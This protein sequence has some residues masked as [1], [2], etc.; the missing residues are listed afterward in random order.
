R[1]H[2]VF[3][4]SLIDDRADWAH[5]PALE[6]HCAELACFALHPR[7]Q[8]L[9]ALLKV[10]PGRPLTLDYFHSPG[11][12]RWVKET[13]AREAIDRIF[14]S[15]SAMAPYAMELRAGRLILDFMD[16]DS[17]KW[18]EY[19]KASRG[20]TRLI[21]ARE[22]RTLH[23]FERRAA[24]RFDHALFVSEQ[25]WRHFRALAPESAERTSFISNGVDF[26]YFSPSHGFENPFPSN[27]PVIVFTGAMDYRPNIQAVE[28]FTHEVLPL[29]RR[30]GHANAAFWIVG[31]N[32]AQDVR[33]LAAQPDV[34]VTGR[35]SDTRPYLAHAHVAV[36]PLR[37]ARGIQNK[38]L[39]AM[40]MGRPVVATPQAFEGLRVV[41][42][43]DLLIAEEASATAR[44]VAE[45]LDGLHCTLGSQARQ[46][47]EQQ[48]DWSTM[49]AALDMLWDQE[50]PRSGSGMEQTSKAE[51]CS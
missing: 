35:V 47:I 40:A 6:A 17:A 26:A 3:V 12:A 29:V 15:C 37:I 32:P 27:A 43:R 25:E 38:V 4:G 11:L 39:E 22:G 50:Q 51:I 23:A 33:R 19:A 16:V 49:L 7:L 20:P 24:A 41:P 36:A 21:W 46:A 5:V 10:S 18:T 8:R 13:V 30:A 44:C 9:R 45:V 48:Y 2:R 28:W 14:V 1:T 42:G 34:H 31:A